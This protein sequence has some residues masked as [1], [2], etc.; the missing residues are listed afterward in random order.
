[1]SESTKSRRK[2]LPPAS[3]HS[4]SANSRR[5]R[6]FVFRTSAEHS[7]AHTLAYLHKNSFTTC[8]EWN[9]Q[10]LCPCKR[11]ECG[12]LT[13]SAHT[14]PTL[15]YLQTKK[16]GLRLFS[17]PCSEGG[18]PKYRILWGSYF[19]QAEWEKENEA[20]SEEAWRKGNA[21]RCCDDRKARE[22]CQVKAKWQWRSY[23]WV[24]WLRV[25]LWIV[26]ARRLLG[27]KTKANTYTHRERLWSRF[28]ILDV[29]WMMNG[30]FCAALRIAAFD[31]NTAATACFTVSSGSC[32]CE[33]AWSPL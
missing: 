23:W 27:A 1:M 8:C 16:V 9:F 15:T 22:I 26:G 19:R 2:N 14:P 24:W 3:L 13:S 10:N 29:E 17:T 31:L 20:A 30:K 5:Q 12:M 7:H 33:N 6:A 25:P 32:K 28:N 4:L 21:K 11:L 18:H